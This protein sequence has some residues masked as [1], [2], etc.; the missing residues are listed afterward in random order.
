MQRR[1]G[2][3]MSANSSF[4]KKKERGGAGGKYFPPLLVFLPT[5]GVDFF[6]LS[7]FLL[8]A[9]RVPSCSVCF[10]PHFFSLFPP[11]LPQ[12][13]LQKKKKSWE[14]KKEEAG[15]LLIR[16]FVYPLPPDFFFKVFSPFFY[17]L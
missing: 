4:K 5:F 8:E 10:P 9:S 11:R 15:T 17:L 16:E 12:I 7:L 3:R 6:L 13:V 1:K 14:K 2:P